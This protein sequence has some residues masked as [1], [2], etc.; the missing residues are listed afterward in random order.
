VRRRHRF[1]SDS[2][3]ARLGWTVVFIAVSVM[4][5]LWGVGWVLAHVSDAVWGPR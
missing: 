5:P 3:W 1:R 4:L 2:E